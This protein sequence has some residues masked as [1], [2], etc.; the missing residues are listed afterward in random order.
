MGEGL[1]TP[2]AQ[3]AGDS[4]TNAN[5]NLRYTAYGNELNR[6]GQIGGQ[7]DSM[8]NATKDR[9]LS[10]ASGYGSLYNQTGALNLSAQQAKDSS[11]Q[12]DRAAQLAAAQSL[13]GQNSANNATS[14]NA[15]N[16]NLQSILNAAQLSQSN[17]GA[18]LGALGAA[19]SLPFTGVN[20]YA[21]LINALT[22]KYGT[23]NSSGTSTTKSSPG[24]GN[25]AA[26]LGGSLLS[27]W[28]TGGFKF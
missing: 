8:Y 7:S 11:F 21:D 3:A 9:N 20:S 14:L 22:A 27:G 16:G 23:T 19:G 6:M 17:A 5:N 1:S 15:A 10:A 26:G 4:I 25:I 2:Y 24:L 13:G 12:N 28:A 18:Q